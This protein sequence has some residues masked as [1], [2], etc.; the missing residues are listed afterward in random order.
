MRNVMMLLFVFFLRWSDQ[1]HQYSIL[2]FPVARLVMRGDILHFQGWRDKCR[3]DA[4]ATMDRYTTTSES[5]MRNTA[6]DAWA[7]AKAEL[8][9]SFFCLSGNY[10]FDFLSAPEHSIE[11][12]GP[13]RSRKGIRNTY[14][15]TRQFF[16][17]HEEWLWFAVPQNTCE[18]M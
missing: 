4:I 15:W 9:K 8:D 7:K 6:D 17:F 12:E 2:W 14:N 3:S 18:L 11:I 16:V 5:A 10:R 1:C 13:G